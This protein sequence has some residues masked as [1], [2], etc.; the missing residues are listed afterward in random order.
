[1]YILQLW[2]TIQHFIPFMGLYLLIVC[3]NRRR[4][5]LIQVSAAAAE[6]WGAPPSQ[7]A[8]RARGPPDTKHPLPPLERRTQALGQNQGAQLHCGSVL[9]VRWPPSAT[10]VLKQR[11]ARL[12]SLHTAAQGEWPIRSYSTTREKQ[13][14]GKSGPMCCWHATVHTAPCILPDKMTAKCCNVLPLRQPR[15][16]MLFTAC[17]LC[18]YKIQN[19]SDL[20]FHQVQVNI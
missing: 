6:S 7:T 9:D 20:Y 17:R 18:Y 16:G 3:L 19:K 13:L 15:P 11:W 1:M 12:L 10:S 14:K 4:H 8:R 5:T 2:T